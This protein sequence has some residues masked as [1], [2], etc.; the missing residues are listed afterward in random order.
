MTMS[1]SRRASRY[2]ISNTLMLASLAA[3]AILVTECADPSA[4]SS[5]MEPGRALFAKGGPVDTNPRANLVWAD[6]VLVNGSMV[7]AGIRGDGRLKNGSP[8]SGAPSNEY[9]AA[10]CGVSAFFQS[11]T[12]LSFKPNSNWTTSMQSACGSQRLYIFYLSGPGAA[13]TANGPHS[14]AYG[15]WSRAVGQSVSQSEAFGVQ[16]PGCDALMFSDSA[17]YAPSSSPQQTRLP[18]VIV[19]GITER[20]W[21][22]ETQNTHQGACV[23]Y[24]HNGSVKSVGPWYVLPFS[25]T[26]TEVSYPWSSYP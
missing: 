26:V 16:L 6:S 1:T 13:G 7:P 24:N 22:I 10:W 8:S 5:L 19:N 18:D 14:I 17:R 2:P 9:Q 15:L 23:T 25:L 21:R 3:L 20:Q 11:G 4:R 12:D